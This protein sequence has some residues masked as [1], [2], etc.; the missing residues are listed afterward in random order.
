MKCSCS[1]CVGPKV[2]ASDK[3]R[4][5]LK[6]RVSA[7]QQLH[8]SNE[9]D[10]QTLRERVVPEALACLDEME[11]DGLQTETHY[12]LLLG[13]L[14]VSYTTLQEYVNSAKFMT[15]LQNYSEALNVDLQQ[16]Q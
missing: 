8:K 10:V 1:S 11:R 6:T 15:K 14:C 3:L 7:I 2:E 13:V 5:T 16:V 9:K 4:A 12:G